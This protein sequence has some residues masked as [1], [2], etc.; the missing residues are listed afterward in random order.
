MIYILRQYMEYIP[1]FRFSNWLTCKLE[2]FAEMSRQG[3][4][5]WPGRKDEDDCLIVIGYVP[6]V[7]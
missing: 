3:R 5:L 7:D 1:N 2:V 6:M 4:D